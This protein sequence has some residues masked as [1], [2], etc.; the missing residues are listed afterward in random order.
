MKRIIL[1]FTLCLFSFT[2]LAVEY[3]IGHYKNYYN[4]KSYSVDVRLKNGKI[5]IVYIFM[6]TKTGVTG[7]F[8]FKGKDLAKFHSTLCAIQDKFSE[9]SNTAIE[10]NISSFSK[11]FNTKLPN[12]TFF[13]LGKT[14]WISNRKCLDPL[15]IVADS[16]PMFMLIGSATALQNKYVSETFNL[17]LLNLSDLE[18]FTEIFNPDEALKKALESQNLTNKFE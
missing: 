11:E 10:N 17:V 9:W 6:A 7:Y 18:K 3:N 5:D 8:S 2:L 4:G 12:G 15:F 13:W 16:K 14:T 1:L